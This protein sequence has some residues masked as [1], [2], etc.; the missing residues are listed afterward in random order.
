MLLKMHIHPSLS[1]WKH[2]HLNYLPQF[3]ILIRKERV[4]PLR[5]LCLLPFLIWLCVF[6]IKCV[7]AYILKSNCPTKPFMKNSRS[8]LAFFTPHRQ[9]SSYELST[10]FWH[11]IPYLQKTCC[12]L[13]PE[14]SILDT[15]HGLS[16][17]EGDKSDLIYHPWPLYLYFI[18][19]HFSSFCP[20]NI[21]VLSAYSSI[22]C[23]HNCT[24]NAAHS[25]VIVY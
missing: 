15:I 17:M 7:Y 8:S 13:L 9:P 18:L 12:V 21:A 19:T 16:F 6:S 10:F 23:F 4:T 1:P 22:Q 2:S 3:S 14:I 24:Y 5:D 20:L 11:F 25:Q